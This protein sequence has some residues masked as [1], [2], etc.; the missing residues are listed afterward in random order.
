MGKSLP[1]TNQKKNMNRYDVKPSPKKFQM[2]M[3]SGWS[4]ILLEAKRYEIG[5]SMF[6]RIN[7]ATFK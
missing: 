1:L 3:N 2:N 4:L 5:L 7:Q 6:G